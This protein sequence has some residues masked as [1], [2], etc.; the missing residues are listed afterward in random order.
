MK[1]LEIALNCSST[2]ISPEQ[3]LKIIPPLWPM[4]SHYFSG[5]KK[6]KKKKING[7]SPPPHSTPR[8]ITSFMAGNPL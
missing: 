2:H 6:K 5:R 7:D 1:E 4:N 3:I 8:D